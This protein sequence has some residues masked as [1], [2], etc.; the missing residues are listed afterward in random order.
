MENWDIEFTKIGKHY[1]AYPEKKAIQDAYRK[2]EQ[3][4]DSEFED[5][6]DE[7]KENKFE[8]LTV[9]NLGAFSTGTGDRLNGLLKVLRDKWDEPLTPN[10]DFRIN[11]IKYNPGKDDQKDQDEKWN[12]YRYPGVGPIPKDAIC[13]SDAIGGLICNAHTSDNDET[14]FHYPY[15]QNPDGQELY[16]STKAFIDKIINSDAIYKGCTWRGD[17]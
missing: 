6:S 10:D 4:S 15:C 8:K 3:D 2:I 12:T 14:S 1:N 17:Y 5:D 16:L 9:L 13:V 11:F 7:E